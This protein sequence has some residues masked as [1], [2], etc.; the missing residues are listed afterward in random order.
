[1]TSDK[2]VFL[3][4]LRR[5]NFSTWPIHSRRQS[6][7]QNKSGTVFLRH[8][9]YSESVKL[10]ILSNLLLGYWSHTIYNNEFL[11]GVDQ[12]NLSI[13]SQQ[14]TTSSNVY[15]ISKLIN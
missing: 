11:K 4:K 1:M 2:L 14:R 9:V 15:D 3:E 5:K 6:Y 7:S 8:G 13:E 12:L 10:E